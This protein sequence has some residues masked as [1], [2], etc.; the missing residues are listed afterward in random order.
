MEGVSGR[1]RLWVRSENSPWM[2]LPWIDSVS[3]FMISEFCCFLAVAACTFEGLHVVPILVIKL[4]KPLVMVQ[5]RRDT[6]GSQWRSLVCLWFIW[7]GTGAPGLAS[8]FLAGTNINQ[9]GAV[10]DEICVLPAPSVSRCIDNVV[11]GDPGAEPKRDRGSTA[12]VLVSRENEVSDNN[13][14]VASTSGSK[15]M[16]YSA[17]ANFPSVCCL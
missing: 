8:V 3:S 12:G 6:W 10:G 11:T 4:Q 15:R 9:G 1:K 17:A 16:E 7:T 13:R 2:N 14:F 5:L